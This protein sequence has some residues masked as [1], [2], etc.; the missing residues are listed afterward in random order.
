MSQKVETF[1]VPRLYYAVYNAAKILGT[2]VKLGASG[3][4]RHGLKCQNANKLSPDKSMM[5]LRYDLEIFPKYL[6][7]NVRY[8]PKYRPG[9]PIATEILALEK[10]RKS[11][12]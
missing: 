10:P 6:A 1:Y 5:P 2:G 12:F 7:P 11:V 3:C 8:G 4:L 9:I